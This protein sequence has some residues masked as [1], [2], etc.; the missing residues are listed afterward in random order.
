MSY[1]RIEREVATGR[2]LEARVLLRSATRLNDAILS[3]SN[4]DL[5]T[6]VSLNTK[7]WM[8]FSS[9]IQDRRVELPAEIARNILALAAFVVGSAPKAFARDRATLET[10]VNINR[11]IAAG[12]SVQPGDSASEAAPAP[13]VA[14]ANQPVSYVTSA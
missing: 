6:A 9:E 13:A 14:P 5:H 4:E 11:R 2:A 8:L 10:L 1:D 7:L 3:T 12:L